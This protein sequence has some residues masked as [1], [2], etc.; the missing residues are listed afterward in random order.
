MPLSM[1]N[2][3]EEGF[4]R[5]VGGNSETKK[6]LE[7]MGFVQG[8]KIRVIAVLNGNMIVQVKEARVAVSREMANRIMTGNL[9][10]EENR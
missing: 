3:E 7:S 10:K 5:S 6:L 1:M 8:Q 2:M 9:R 4:V